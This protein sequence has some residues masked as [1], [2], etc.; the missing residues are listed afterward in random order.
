MR[1]VVGGIEQEA[2][3]FLEAAIVEDAQLVDD[4][5]QPLDGFAIGARA[6]GDLHVDAEIRVES[7]LGERELREHQRRGPG[8]ELGDDDLGH[9]ERGGERG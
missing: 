1:C 7:G 5:F 9:F 6:L 2:G 3:L 4:G 8:L